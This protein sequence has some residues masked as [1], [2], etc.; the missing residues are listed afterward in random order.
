M[1]DTIV[2]RVGGKAKLAQWIRGLLPSH[3]IYV[4][5]FGGSFA[6]GLAL[7][8]E[9]N[10][11]KYRKIYN[12]LD[13]HIV[14]FFRVLRDNPTEL[15]DQVALTPYSRE[16]FSNAVAYI[17]DP[18]EPWKDGDPVEW[19][20]NYLIYNRQSIFGK[21]TG[22]WCISLHGENICM[23]WATL[24]PL[25]QKTATSLKDAYI[26]C[27]DYRELLKKWDSPQACF[28]LD[29]PYEGVEKDFYHVNKKDGFD[30]VAMRDA[31]AELQGSWAISYY[32]G[33]VIRDLYKD[34]DCTFHTRTVKK[35]MQTGGSKDSAIEVLIVHESEWADDRGDDCFN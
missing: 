13:G 20:R 21:E 25:I 16:E 28:Y 35:H 29:P 31:V 15:V 32:D 3:T 22:N 5:P 12:D 17:E 30:H 18:A 9:S 34:L 14:N 33:E 1:A 23:T 24:P 8:Q 11:S 7:S 6:V 2:K 26:E 4:E 19:A 10:K 27:L